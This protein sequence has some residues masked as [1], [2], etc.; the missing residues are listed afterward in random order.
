VA[1][2]G[3]DPA[4]DG[5]YTV[6]LV[7]VSLKHF[8]GFYLDCH[9][10]ASVEGVKQTK[11]LG[12]APRQQTARGTF[13]VVTLQTSSDAKRAAL[14]LT[15]P[16][17]VVADEWGRRYFRSP[18]AEKAVEWVNGSSTD[19][20]QPLNPR[21]GSFAKQLVFDLPDEVQ[22]PRPLVTEG[23]WMERLLKMILIGDED[24]LWHAKTLFRL[25]PG[26]PATAI[27]E[28]VPAPI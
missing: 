9:L 4:L 25:Q 11:T 7:Y 10:S 24:S 5:G 22:D 27:T 28:P 15:S 19:F 26:A 23:H 16:S 14:R 3:W 21:G 1:D 13:Q 17:A 12:S 8:C 2:T 20:G 18:E 6:L